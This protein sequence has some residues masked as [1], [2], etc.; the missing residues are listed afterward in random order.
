VTGIARTSVRFAAAIARGAGTAARATIRATDVGVPARRFRSG[1]LASFRRIVVAVLVSQ[2][3]AG[4]PRAGAQRPGPAVERG[5]GTAA[6]TLST[7]AADVDPG[8]AP[9]AAA[10]RGIRENRPWVVFYGSAAQ[11]GPLDRIAAAFRLIV[12]DADPAAANFTPSEIAR[13]K[14]G[15]R[16]TVL[17]YL[18]VGSCERDRDYWSHAPP[19]LVP[20]GRNRAAQLG[21]YQGYPREVWMNPGNRDHR[22]LLLEHVAPRLSAT[23][24]DGFFLDNFE[25]VEHGTRTRHGPCDATCVRGAF[26]LLAELRRRFPEGILVLQNATSDAIRLHRLEDGRSVPEVLDGVSREEVYAPVYDPRAEHELLAWKAMDL[27][28]RG[29]AFSITTEDYVGD[30]ARADLARRAYDRSLARGFSPY[31]TTASSNQAVLCP[32]SLR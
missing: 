21:A 7:G 24:V 2:A 5:V 10:G 3:L 19:G 6:R 16:N 17:S 1:D 20:C 14:A 11:L 22:R 27:T 8:Q 31:A 23:G 29:R 28:V 26:R 4:A 12:I 13:L 9:L 15:G 32:W 18:N 30:C 25:L